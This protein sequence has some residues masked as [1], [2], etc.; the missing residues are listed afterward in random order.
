MSRGRHTRRFLYIV[1]T[2]GD[3]A[4]QLGNSISVLRQY[5]NL[6]VRYVTLTHNCHNAFADSSA[7]IP[8][9]NGLRY[10]QICTHPLIFTSSLYSPFGY[11]LIDEMNRLGILV[12]LSHTSDATAVQAFDYSRAPVIWSH[13]SARAIHN[14]PRNVPDN[15]IQ[16]LGTGQGKKDGIIMASPA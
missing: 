7:S 2:S 14:V 5:Y 11:R 16:L 12:D 3:R 9:H 10:V 13:S 6:G 4:H 15:I 8:L 1:L